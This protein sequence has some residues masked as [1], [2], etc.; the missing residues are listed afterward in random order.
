MCCRIHSCCCNS[1]ATMS[2]HHILMDPSQLSTPKQSKLP[3]STNWDVCVLCQ[4]STDEPL[5]CP[6]RSTKLATIGSGYASLAE[7]LLRFQTLQQM[8]LDLSLERLNDG[9][10]TESTLKA[11][12]AKWHKKCRLKFNKKVFNEHSQA[13]LTTEQQRYNSVHTRSAYCHQQSTEPTCFFCNEPANSA[14]LHK[15]STHNMTQMCESAPL[16]LR[17]L[18]CWPSLQQET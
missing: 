9:D 16:I 6:L 8:P 12:R 15:A 17:T 4:V 3:Q 14:D 10:G 1:V 7:D 13:E 5:Q 11:H 2:K 18:L